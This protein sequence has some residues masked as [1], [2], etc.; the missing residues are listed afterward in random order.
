M[1][2]LNRKSVDF[3]SYIKSSKIITFLTIDKI[4]LHNFYLFFDELTCKLFKYTKGIL[5]V[6]EKI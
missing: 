2:R 4:A 3:N 6:R 1:T 5:H